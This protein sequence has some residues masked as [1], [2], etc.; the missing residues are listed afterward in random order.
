[1]PTALPDNPTAEQYTK[2]LPILIKKIIADPSNFG[3]VPDDIS[4]TTG[5]GKPVI[6]SGQFVKKF[7]SGGKTQTQV[8]KY[9]LTQ[10]SGEFFLSYLPVSGVS[11]TPTNLSEPT[12]SKLPQMMLDS[13]KNQ[14]WIQDFFSY[15][16]LNE[17]VGYS[18]D[19]A[20]ELAEYQADVDN[21]FRTELAAINA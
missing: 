8:Y 9:E 20:I 3:A 2:I 14:D 17:N 1:M 12:P 10:E 21:W 4:V 11:D 16:T 18:R 13:D 5:N 15:V 6:A 7:I 19:K